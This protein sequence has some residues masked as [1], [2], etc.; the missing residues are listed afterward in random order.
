MQ[1]CRRSVGG[2]AMSGAGGS[3]AG[4]GGSAGEKR[5]HEVVDLTG[6]SDEQDNDEK[7][8]EQQQVVQRV[9]ECIDTKCRTHDAMWSRNFQINDVALH[10]YNGAT[11]EESLNH[12]RQSIN[13]HKA[14][15]PSEMQQEWDEFNKKI[16]NETGRSVCNFRPHQASPLHKRF[17]CL[18]IPITPEIRQ[19][20]D[21]ILTHVKTQAD[22]NLQGLQQAFAEQLHQHVVASLVNNKPAYCRFFLQAYRPP[23]LPYG[24]G[25]V[26]RLNES[27]DEMQTEYGNM[28]PWSVMIQTRGKHN[29][30]LL[31]N[32]LNHD[33][34]EINVVT[35]ITSEWFRMAEYRMTHG[36]Y[37]HPYEGL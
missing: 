35:P 29:G 9:I 36:D 14:D 1:D 23:F 33:V 32:Y 12:L 25:V 28:R 20:M 4:T 18:D 7:S 31:T 10:G 24:F 34:D 8:K 37:P 6:S 11:D 2:V 30:E 27:N 3:A 5:K 26:V 13:Q 19:A 22:K 16:T 21:L 17:E 15:E